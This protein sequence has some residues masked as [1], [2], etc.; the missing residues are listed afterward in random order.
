MKHQLSIMKRTAL[1]TQKAKCAGGFVGPHL[2]IKL[3]YEGNTFLQKF[4]PK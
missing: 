2:S 1:Q 3:L 4:T